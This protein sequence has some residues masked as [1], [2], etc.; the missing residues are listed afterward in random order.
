MTYRDELAE[1]EAE[2]DRLQSMIAYHERAGLSLHLDLPLWFRLVLLGIAC[3]IGALVIAGVLAD[4]ISLSYVVFAVVFLA[5]TAYISTL[6]FSVFGTSMR[7]GDLV[8]FLTLTPT[9]PTPGAPE[10][11]Q[12]LS[13]CE[14][15]IMKLKE[16]RP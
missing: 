10:I 7:V 3:G 9:I 13:D 4:Q 6:K 11:R 15:Q 2:R 1:L 16:R 8:G 14:T 12:L 5:V